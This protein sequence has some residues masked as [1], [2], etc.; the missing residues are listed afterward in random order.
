MNAPITL[1]G[2]DAPSIAFDGTRLVLTYAAGVYPSRCNADDAAVR[3]LPSHAIVSAEI[4]AVR[5]I[6][7]PTDAATPQRV[8]YVL[9]P[10]PTLTESPK[11]RR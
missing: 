4:D 9:A 3:A 6:G 8:T 5:V 2:D 10:K 7:A 1:P 11:P